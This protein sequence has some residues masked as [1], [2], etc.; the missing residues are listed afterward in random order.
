[1]DIFLTV[2]M[3]HI[4][5]AIVVMG[6]GTGIAFFMFMANRS[7]NT[8]AI[9]VTA[10]SVILGDWLFTTPAVILQLSSGLYL[11]SYQGYSFSS[12]WFYSVIGLFLFIGVCWIPAPCVR[13]VVTPKF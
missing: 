9:L 6:T 10:N 4:L 13:L 11:M 7:N 8:Q 2:K 1:M 5:A 12:V 3:I